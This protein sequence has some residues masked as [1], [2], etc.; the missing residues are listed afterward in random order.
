MGRL[1]GRHIAS[2]SVLLMAACRGMPR[3]VKP[4]PFG[5]PYAVQSVRP[6]LAISIMIIIK[7][8]WLVYRN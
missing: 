8:S 6:L 5:P 4:P 1:T 2:A 7:K 3:I